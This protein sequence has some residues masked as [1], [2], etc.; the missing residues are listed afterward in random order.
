MGIWD[1]IPELGPGDLGTC[2]L[3]GGACT[4]SVPLPLYRYHL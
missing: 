1:N 4:P 2:A 3:V